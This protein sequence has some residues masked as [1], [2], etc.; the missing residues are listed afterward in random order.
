M[1]LP[2]NVHVSRHPCLMAKLSRLRSKGTESREVKSLVNDIATILGCEAL[3]TALTPV[4]GP[5]VRYLGIYSYLIRTFKYR[6]ESYSI[7]IGV[8][9]Y[10]ILPI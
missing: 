1:S 2:S 4:D 5:K 10:L 7:A 3:A 9:G 8:A 6:L